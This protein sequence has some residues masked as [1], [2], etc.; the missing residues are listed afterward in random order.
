MPAPTTAEQHRSLRPPPAASRLPFYL[1]LAYGALIVYASLHPFYG[2]RD[3][4]LPVFYFLDAGW[5]RYWTGFDLIINILAYL[6]LGFFVTLTPRASGRRWRS[7][8]AAIVLGALLSF[9]LETL[10][11]WLPTRVASN[12]DLAS[13]ALGGGIG[14]L[15]ALLLGKRF[16]SFVDLLQRRLLAPIHNAEYGLILVSLWLLTQLSPETFL[17]GAGDLRQLL[18]LAPVVPYAAHSFFA[19]ETGIIICNFVAI[20]L[21]TRTLLASGFRPN[22]A[23]LIFFALALVIRSLAAIILVDPINAFAW[24]T[25]G[26]GLGLLTGAAV[27]TLSFLLPPPLRIAFAGLALMAGTVLVNITP[28]NPYSAAALATWRQGHFLNFN[29]LTRLVASVWP[30]LALPYLIVLGRKL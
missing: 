5:P 18:D 28:P 27:L 21:I 11:T 12:L 4:N 14:A 2:W 9:S 15:L 26:A 30:F 6:P 17:F 24:L 1:A 7:A 13:N 19:I 29:G 23:L 22:L 10:Q 20:G 3:P 16:F 8:L 25:P